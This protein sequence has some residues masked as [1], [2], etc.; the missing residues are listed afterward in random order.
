MARPQTKQAL[1]EMIE[2]ER[3]RLLQAL[4]LLTDRQM[5]LPGACEVWS[6]NDIL[7]H[8]TDWEQRLTLVSGWIEGRGA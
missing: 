8:L 7:S 1:Y 5:E 2:F 3:D 4:D 6:V